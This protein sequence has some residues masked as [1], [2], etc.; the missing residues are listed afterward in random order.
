MR[1]VMPSAIGRLSTVILA[2]HARRGGDDD[3]VTVRAVARAY[4]PVRCVRPADGR[5]AQ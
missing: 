2:S 5:Q 4:F 1:D 3:A